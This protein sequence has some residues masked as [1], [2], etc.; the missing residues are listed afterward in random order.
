M[1]VGLITGVTLAY[2]AVSFPLLLPLMGSPVDMQLVM[3]AYVS[4]FVGVLL[5]PVHLCLVLT[6]EYF[7]ASLGGSYRLLIL[8]CAII[9]VVAFLIVLM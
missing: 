2:I 5:S 1:I 7:H 9:M 8:P 3:L 4:G 6:R